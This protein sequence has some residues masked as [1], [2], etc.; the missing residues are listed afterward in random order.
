M[1]DGRFLCRGVSW[2]RDGPALELATPDGAQTELKLPVVGSAQRDGVDL[3]FRVLSGYGERHCLG[4]HSVC[5]PDSRDHTACPQQATAERGYQCGRCFA[6]DDLRFMHDV[7]RSGVAPDGLLSYLAQEHW[8]YVAT[9]ADGTSKIG[10]ASNL[11]KWHRL[12]EQGAVVA[13]YVARADDGRIVRVL[14][15]AVTR[16]V[17]LVQAVR[18]A[19]KTLALVSPLPPGRLDGINAGFAASVRHLLTDG[20]DLPGFRV[21]DQRWE[22]PSSWSHVL[23]AVGA[24]PYPHNLAAGEH[25][26]RV[27]ALVGPT[28]LSFIG[29]SDVPLLADLSRLK[30]RRIELG[31]YCSVVPEV[32]AALF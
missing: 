2:H 20:L 5:G 28:A 11:R 29:G 19:A 21:A 6:R 14:E 18:S 4:F 27:E 10:T 9:F 7:H 12:A 26:F 16:H 31:R 17:G 15:D 8:L 24:Q 25:G 22:A 23:S 3:G 1:D 13:R 30:G 32:Q